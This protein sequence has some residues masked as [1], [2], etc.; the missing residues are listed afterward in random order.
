M[1]KIGGTTAHSF[2]SVTLSRLEF[3]A[4]PI[5]VVI[6]LISYG[7]QFNSSVSTRVS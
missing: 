1:K 3:E 7:Y 4:E 6:T 5:V 2:C